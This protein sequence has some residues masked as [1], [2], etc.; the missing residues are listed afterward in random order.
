[1]DYE[2]EIAILS[3]EEIA[4]I[5]QFAKHHNLTLNTVIQGA[6][7]LV[8]KEYTQQREIVMGVTLSG[9]SMELLGIEEMMGLFI[10]TLPLRVQFGASDVGTFLKELQEK[11][12]E[13][14]HYSY[15]SLA[16]I[17]SFV[18]LEGGLFDVLFIFENY[19][20]DEEVHNLASDFKIREVRGI[21]KTEYPLTVVVEPGEAGL[22]FTLNYQTV[23]FN[24]KLIQRFIK[25]VRLALSHLIHKRFEEF[26]HSFG[27]LLAEEKE[28]FIEWN[29]TEVSYPKEECIHTLF[30]RQAKKT[31]KNVAVVFEDKTLC[32]GELNEKS[33]QLAH[34]LR[35]FIVVAET[36]IAVALPRS[37]D[38]WIALLGI[39]KAGAVYVPLDLSY[40]AERLAYILE[41]S[42]AAILLSTSLQAELVAEFDYSGIRIDLDLVQ[43]SLEKS[44]KE[45]ISISFSKNLAYIMYTSGSTGRPKGVENTH[46]GLVNRLLWSL[47]HYAISEEDCLLHIAAFG[48]DISI[49]EMIFPLLSG[50]S[51]VLAS[52]DER[53]DVHAILRL[54]KE[55]KV[56]LM[57]FVPSLLKHFVQVVQMEGLEKDV[58]TLK[59][60]VTGGES[61]S[62]ELRQSFLSVFEGRKLHLA[63]GPTEAAIS[64]TH[65]NCKDPKYSSKTPIGKAISNSEIYI[66]NR[67]LEPVPIGVVGEIYIGGICLGRGYSNRPDLTADSF[68]PNPFKQWL[69]KDRRPQKEN[70]VEGRRDE[71]SGKVKQDFSPLRLY[72]TGDL[73]R[74]L[75]DGNIE[76]LGR[77]DQ[78]V[79][80]RG[81]RIELAEIETALR[82]QGF[83]EAVVL[84]E[85]EASGHKRLIAY[86]EPGDE[87]IGTLDIESEHLSSAGL[88]F[89]VL[90]GETLFHFTEQ[91]KEKLLKSLPDYMIPAFFVY[92]N[93]IP[94]TVNGKLDYKALPGL[95]LKLQ[96]PTVDYALPKTDIEVILYSIWLEVLRVEQLSVHDHFFRIGGDSIISIQLVARARQQGIYINVKDIFENPTIARLASVAKHLEKAVQFTA[97]QSQ[98]EGE[99]P[100]TPIQHYFFAEDFENHHHFNQSLLLKPKVRIELRLLNEAFKK[101][102]LQHDVLRNAYRYSFDK[103][104]VQSCCAIEECNFDCSQINLASVSDGSF[105]S[106]LE[107]ECSKIQESMDIEIAPLM[108]VCLFE[109]NIERGQ[110]VLIVIHH[111]VIDTVSWQILLEDLGNIYDSLSLGKEVVLPPKTHSYQQW[112]MALRTYSESELFKEEHSYWQEVERNLHPIPLDCN[113][114]AAIGEESEFIEAV[115]PK[116]ET[117]KLL[118]RVPEAYRTEINDV[119]LTA[120]VCAIGDWTGEYKLS[121]TL[122]G[123]GRE[124][125]V[126]DLDLSRSVG[127]YTS[128]FPVTVSISN[129][130]DVGESIKRVKETLR[131]IP[132]KGIGYG[133]LKYMS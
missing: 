55:Y 117:S 86:V 39:L 6:V 33:N 78:Q 9:R 102:L 104:W 57:H 81:H 64:I 107:K 16:E 68:I 92:I 13:F 48:F 26:P 15:S 59:Q 69:E 82:G 61:L 128:V 76:F 25:H 77:R 122:E 106:T 22:R 58:C 66:L 88:M 118:H 31:P 103:G 43:E 45:D 19:P 14:N 121:L 49:W 114:G 101:L 29:A 132:K 130:R 11:T 93:K 10:N 115:L 111:L 98:V 95:A 17:Q 46:G 62:T 80:I 127:W 63:Y 109:G 94:V 36:R 65:W 47:Q 40:P 54:I 18:G 3:R 116:E 108:K 37:I 83:G 67:A 123:H 42:E 7:A 85:E 90:H 74:Y 24:Q 72:R 120:L 4:L 60:V 99:I 35:T 89:S 96:D 97:Q 23:H 2:T 70:A 1:M 129:P 44:R 75:L 56:S 91:V 53:R 100:L 27:L 105:E 32:Y 30:E 124:M 125:I 126:E 52:E 131:E 34:Y 12:Q 20:L 38:M 21:E 8:L 87:L 51:V 112:S 110:R 5:I 50:G 71:D 41:D 133:I 113:E 84:A 79:K 28:T 119:L 73:G